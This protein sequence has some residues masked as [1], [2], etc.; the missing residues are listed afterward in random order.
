MFTCCMDVLAR[1][2]QM[3]PWLSVMFV[4]SAQQRQRMG[5]GFNIPSMVNQPL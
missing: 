3:A 5:K 1:H 2:Q 4:Y